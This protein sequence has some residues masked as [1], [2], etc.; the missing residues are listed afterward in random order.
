MSP[1]P[2]EQ[3]LMVPDMFGGRQWRL[4]SQ[5]GPKKGLGEAWGRP[6]RRGNSQMRG[7]GAEQAWCWEEPVLLDGG[8]GRGVTNVWA[9]VRG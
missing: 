6:D 3:T 2:A 4:E 1:C 7:H 5:E 9:E 8:R